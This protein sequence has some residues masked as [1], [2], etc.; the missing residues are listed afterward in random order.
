MAAAAATNLSQ[1]LLIPRTK[2]T[3][4]EPTVYHPISLLNASKRVHWRENYVAKVYTP[5]IPENP[6]PSPAPNPKKRNHPEELPKF[7]TP[8][9]EEKDTPFV[10]RIKEIRAQM[11]PEERTH[12]TF[13]PSSPTTALTPSTGARRP[14]VASISTAHNSHVSRQSTSQQRLETLSAS[15]ERAEKKKA[16]LEEHA[17]LEAELQAA[18]KERERERKR[19]V[20]IGWRTLGL[21]ERIVTSDDEI[22]PGD[23]I[24]GTSAVRYWEPESPKISP[25]SGDES[26]IS[27]NLDNE[28]SRHDASQHSAGCCDELRSSTSTTAGIGSAISPTLPQRHSSND[29]RSGSTSSDGSIMS[30]ETAITTPGTEIE[31]EELCVCFERLQLGAEKAGRGKKTDLPL[32]VSGEFDAGKEDPVEGKEKADI[33]AA[34]RGLKILLEKVNASEWVA[35]GR[36]EV[37]QIWAGV[38]KAALE[39]LEKAR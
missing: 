2:T 19:P 11:T 15:F 26:D 22:G 37:W 9:F 1:A 8:H 13:T 4:N 17:R 21:H 28:G 33:K 18:E 10:T 6:R 34:A 12:Y 32:V 14:S 38:T 25:G 16:I 29:T 3:P 23:I 30:M 5:I 20:P 31:L 35:E 27:M 24:V 7:T 39:T 36:E